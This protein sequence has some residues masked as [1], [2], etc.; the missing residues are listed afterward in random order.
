MPVQKEKTSLPFVRA[1]NFLLEKKDLKP[2]E[3]LVLIILCRFWPSPFWGSNSTIAKSVSLSSRQIERLLKSLKSR[4]II[5]TGYAHK[6]RNG[7]NHTVRVIVPLCIPGKCVLTDCKTTTD[8]NDGMTP[9]KNDGQIPTNQAQTTVRNVD[10]IERNRKENREATP[11][12]SP[13]KKQ[14]KAL[15]EKTMPKMR[16]TGQEF[17]ERRRRQIKALMESP[18]Q[19]MA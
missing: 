17:Q 8:R 14:A 9:V 11:L 2:A 6:N 15:I 16:M 19:V 1:Y 7:K 12:P 5:K 4:G 3:K 10:L 18:N 13:A